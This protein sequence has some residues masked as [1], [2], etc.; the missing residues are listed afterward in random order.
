MWEMLNCSWVKF[1]HSGYCTRQVFWWSW[2]WCELSQLVT[3]QQSAS[4]PDM[5]IE[6]IV[7]AF[8]LYCYQI[9]WLRPWTKLNIVLYCMLSFSK[10]AVSQLSCWGGTKQV[11]HCSWRCHRPLR[12]LNWVV[13]QGCVNG[14]LWKEWR[15]ILC[16]HIST[17]QP[18]ASFYFFKH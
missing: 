6:A 9:T 13:R 14:Y 7:K 18:F 5:D 3:G 17:T 16:I 1:L 11:E 12:C 2:I 4:C 8:K 15:F 10:A